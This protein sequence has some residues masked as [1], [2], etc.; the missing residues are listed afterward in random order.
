LP[1]STLTVTARMSS[2][3]T[4]ARTVSAWVGT[5]CA[6]RKSVTRRR[7]VGEVISTNGHGEARFLKRQLTDLPSTAANE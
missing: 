2:P 5:C 7:S 4:R 1:S 3:N 6:Q